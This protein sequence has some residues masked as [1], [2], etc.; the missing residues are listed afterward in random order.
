MTLNENP[1]AAEFSTAAA[2]AFASEVSGKSSADAVNASRSAAAVGAKRFR[3]GLKV[4]SNNRY[5]TTTTTLVV[6]FVVVVVDFGRGGVHSVQRIVVVDVSS[7]SRRSP[8][9]RQLPLAMQRQW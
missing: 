7:S 2:F 3:R 6:V 4:V 9:T 8:S 5:T 1:A